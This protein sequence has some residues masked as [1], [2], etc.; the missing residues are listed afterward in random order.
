[1][2]RLSRANFSSLPPSRPSRMVCTKAVNALVRS[3]I[4]TPSV[5]LELLQKFDRLALIAASL[6][7]PVDGSRKGSEDV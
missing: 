6:R 2:G 3:S 7:K 5:L 1:M 4:N